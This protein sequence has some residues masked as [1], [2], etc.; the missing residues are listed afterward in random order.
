[1]AIDG[2]EFFT[3]WQSGVQGLALRSSDWKE[4][5]NSTEQMTWLREELEQSRM[6]KQ[7]LFVYVDCDPRE[8][9]DTLKRRLA[10]GKALCIFGPSKN[11]TFEEVVLY[12]F[13]DDDNK[14][15]R[16]TD[17]EEDEQDNHSTRMIGVHQIGL[18]WIIVEGRDEDWKLEYTP[19]EIT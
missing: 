17:S 9:A 14:S 6:T 13:E 4:G 15:I 18:Q 2:S 12:S 19:I 8:L 7:F 10:R 1:V 3:F 5:S 16:S 11:D